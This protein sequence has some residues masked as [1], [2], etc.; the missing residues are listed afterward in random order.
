ML[1]FLPSPFTCPWS[2]GSHMTPACLCKVLCAPDHSNWCSF[3]HVTETRP[4]SFPGSFHSEFG[5]KFLSVLQ[6]SLNWN[7]S[8][9]CHTRHTLSWQPAMWRYLS[10]GTL[11]PRGSLPHGECPP[12]VGGIAASTEKP[13]SES[14]QNRDSWLRSKAPF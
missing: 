6:G 10:H 11:P 9:H 3:G 12:A 1:T 2:H 13:G 8:Q 4:K 7:V 14:E 5:K